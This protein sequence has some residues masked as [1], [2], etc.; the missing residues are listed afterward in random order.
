[1]S[2]FCETL[3]DHFQPLQNSP[4]MKSLGRFVVNSVPR[5][6]R[7]LIHL[8]L[9][10][11]RISH[12]TCEAHCCGVA[13][14]CST[15]LTER[16]ADRTSGECAAPSLQNLIG[17]LDRSRPTKAI[18]PASD[19]M[20][21]IAHWNQLMRRNSSPPNP[22]RQ[23]VATPCLKAP[24]PGLYVSCRVPLRTPDFRWRQRTRLTNR[25]VS[26]SDALSL[27]FFL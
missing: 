23:F 8:S 16:V 4:R 19:Y 10:T 12:A 18:P 25:P 24:Q 26:A 27:C 11:A 5:L 22:P 2:R 20:P 17:G 13:I 9:A 21:C 15:S 3:A 14:A 7:L 6:G 1:M